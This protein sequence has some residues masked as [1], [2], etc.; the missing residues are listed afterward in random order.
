VRFKLIGCEVLT[1]EICLCVAQSPHTIDIEFTAKDLHNQSP[2]LRRSLQERI[3]AAAAERRYEAILLGFGLCGNSTV[4][5]QAR[6]IPLVLPRAHDCC[7][8]FL[9]SREAFSRH[10][11][12]QLSAPFTSAGYME[13]S[14][15]N[16]FHDPSDLL[17]LLGGGR[18]FAD[19][20]AEYGEETA[21][22][23][24]ETLLGASGMPT[25]DQTIYFIDIPEFRHLDFASQCRERARAE[26]KEAIELPGSIN[27]I[28]KLTFGEWDDDFLIVKPG[29]RIAGIY[30]F[31]TIMA[32]EENG[33]MTQK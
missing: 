8:L 29:Q 28:R 14:N 2:I 13:R 26:G 17:A 16:L 19:L 24:R 1:R 32:A 4:E 21:G 15:G 31:E 23:I 20:V 11:G 3:D 12:D 7:T 5:L 33:P 22:Y 27:L 10:F 25:H 6:E 9:G 30:D 18:S